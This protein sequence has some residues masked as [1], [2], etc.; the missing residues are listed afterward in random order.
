M[1]KKDLKITIDEKVLEKGKN[2]ILNLSAFFEECLKHYLGYANGTIAIGNINEI[3]DKIGKLQVELYLINQN[4]DAKES[5]R[6][7]ENE[8]KNKAWR[9]LWN[10]FRPRL[11]PD[12]TL[13]KKAVEQL[14]KNEEEL[15]DILD[16]VHITD[17]KIDTNSWQ[18][19]SEKYEKYRDDEF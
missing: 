17:I 1:T 4:Y 13:L 11:I 9:F 15:E 16:W 19:V 3:T 2:A 14:G 7:V 12:E 8:E 18:D 10:D 6:R 5:M